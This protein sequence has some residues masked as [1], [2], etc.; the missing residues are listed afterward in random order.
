MELDA[1]ITDP[2]QKTNNEI[3]RKGTDAAA[4]AASGAQAT[5]DGAAAALQT[6]I[7]FV[8]MTGSATAPNGWLLCDGSSLLRSDYPELF[9]A[10]GTAFGTADSTHFNIPDMRGKFARGVD[11]SAGVDPNK[12][13][14]TAL[15]TGGATGNNVGSYQPDAS[16]IH[17][18]RVMSSLGLNLT[19]WLASAGAAGWVATHAG[20]GGA[21]FTTIPE[22]D[23][24]GGTYRGSTENRPINIYLN[25]A[26]RYI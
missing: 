7:G 19:M 18:H 21:V 26:I 15:K 20:G 6:F 3:L 2:L 13:T 1:N 14:R 8:G 25:F 16:Q 11:G 5:A 12:A 4:M 24:T 10:I 17:M 23:G 22:N 9:A